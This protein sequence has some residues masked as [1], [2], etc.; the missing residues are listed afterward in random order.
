[1]CESV[2]SWKFGDLTPA[3]KELVHNPSLKM[4]RLQALRITFHRAILNV[5]F[6]FKFGHL[7]YDHVILSFEFDKCII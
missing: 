1:M 2:T 3:S 7:I 6:S 5:N 4:Y